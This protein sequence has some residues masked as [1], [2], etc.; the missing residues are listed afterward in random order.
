[1]G[2]EHLQFAHPVHESVHV[3]G[4]LPGYGSGV[5]RRPLAVEVHPASDVPC[6]H[7]AAR[8]RAHLR[9]DTGTGSLVGVLTGFGGPAV[10]HG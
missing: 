5:R 3:T 4:E 1:M 7:R 9:T 10:S 2:A 6:L 8:D